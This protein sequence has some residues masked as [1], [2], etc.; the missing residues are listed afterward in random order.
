MA[1]RVSFIAV[2]ARLGMDPETPIREL[3][4]GEYDYP[5]AAQRWAAQQARTHPDTSIAYLIRV[6][7]GWTSGISWVYIGPNWRNALGGQTHAAPGMVETCAHHGVAV[8]VN[9]EPPPR[10][11]PGGMAVLASALRA[12]DIEAAVATAAQVDALRKGIDVDADQPPQG[13]PIGIIQVHEKLGAADVQD[14]AFQGLTPEL[15]K[16]G[17][18]KYPKQFGGRGVVVA[19]LDTGCRRQVRELGDRVIGYID[20]TG[21]DALAGDSNG[22]G[23]FVA[24]QI[25]GVLASGVQIG[26]APAASILVVKVLTNAGWGTDTMIARGVY[27]AISAKAH[28][29]T[30]SLGGGGEMPQTKAALE[31]ADK[32]GILICAACGNDGAGSG[33]IGYPAR[34]GVCL[35]IGSCD[36]Q[37][38]RSSFSQTSSDTDLY[39]LG[40]AQLGVAPSGKLE[41][42]SGTSMATPHAAS[43]RA[44][45]VEQWMTDGSNPDDW[46][47]LRR[48]LSESDTGPSTIRGV[49]PGDNAGFVR[50]GDAHK[51]ME[52]EVPPPP[53]PG[54]P[55]GLEAYPFKPDM[56]RTALLGGI[57]EVMGGLSAVLD[58][59]HPA[60]IVVYEGVPPSDA[61]TV[62]FERWAELVKDMGRDTPK[63]SPSADEPPPLAA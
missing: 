24:T 55:P 61:D 37:L 1:G 35:A 44:L 13:E 62:P 3:I 50:V 8:A 27:A 11:E 60:Y 17:Y 14:I 52:P 28:I 56:P 5:G 63:A 57:S 36:D 59:G 31:A 9:G 16:M 20:A 19:V 39:T 34:Y 30:M 41:R 40:A 38:T 15:E 58:T 48:A 25:A 22:H 26:G 29:I 42:W 7:D 51:Y 49:N 32:A 33:Q 12:S 18:G 54:P 2:V 53:P 10:D 46:D 23:T 47:M 43:A 6:A 45:L 21:Q 4:S